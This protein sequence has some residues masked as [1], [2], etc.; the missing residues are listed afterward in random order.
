MR[1]I[2]DLNG[3]RPERF[4]CPRCRAQVFL[5]L[6]NYIRPHL[7]PHRSRSSEC[8]AVGM[9]VAV[10]WREEFTRCARCGE[11]VPTDDGT[12]VRQHSHGGKTCNGSGRE[13]ERWRWLKLGDGAVSIDLDEPAPPRQKDPRSS[14]PN[15][16]KQGGPRPRPPVNVKRQLEELVRTELSPGHVERRAV[17][18]AEERAAQRRRV[19]EAKKHENRSPIVVQVVSGGLP[20]SARR[21]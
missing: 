20:G 2:D 7:Q 8:S 17:Q 12:L 21:R 11:P 10:R 14:R 3:I 15:A 13:A 16:A 6:D 18:S 19:A 4:A 9:R 5:D 1:A